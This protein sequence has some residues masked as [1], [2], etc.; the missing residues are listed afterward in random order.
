LLLLLLFLFCL[1]FIY[2]LVST[3]LILLRQLTSPPPPFYEKV[4]FVSYIPFELFCDPKENN[5][6]RIEDKEP[7]VT[8][9]PPPKQH[10]KRQNKTNY[11]L[12]RTTH[13]E[14]VNKI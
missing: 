4:C 9:R 1:V 5:K 14:G 13:D 8:S 12:S 2:R 7:L 11:Q 6:C 10:P 3:M